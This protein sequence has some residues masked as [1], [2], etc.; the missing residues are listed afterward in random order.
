MKKTSAIRVVTVFL[1]VFLAGSAYALINPRFTPIHLVQQ[2]ETIALLKLAPPDEHG[3][4]A[5]EVRRGLKGKLAAAKFTIDLSTA[6]QQE[7]AKTAGDNMRR[8]G[9]GPALLFIGKDEDQES[10]A[11]LALAGQWLR[12]E[13]REGG[14]LAL[15]GHDT[16]MQGTWAGGTDMLLL[17]VEYI[18]ADDDADVP[19]AVGYGWGA[20]LTLGRIA[21][22]VHAMQAV[23]LAGKGEFALFI[24]AEG[25][26]RLYRW[27][28]KADGFRDIASAVKLGSKSRLA[29]WADLNGDGRRDL[30]DWDGRT[31]NMWTQ[32]ADG[33]FGAK[34]LDIGGQIKGGC[35]SLCAVDAG[36]EKRSGLLVGTPEGPLLLKPRADG[37]FQVAALSRGAAAAGLGAPIQCLA[38]DLDGD[39]LFD[40]LEL[41]SEGSLFYKGQGAGVFAEPVK[42]AIAAG[43]GRTVASVGDCDA[44]GR[45]DL[46]TCSEANCRLWHN[47]GDLKFEETFGLSGEIS[48]TAVPG[49]TAVTTCDINND[50]RQDL[51]LA[52]SDGPPMIFFNRGFRSFGKALEMTEKNVIPETEGGQ[53]SATVE[54]F[55]GDGA[56]DLAMTLNDGTVMVFLRKTFEDEKPLEARASLPP[57]GAFA[58]P[59]R[60][61]GWAGTRCLG[62][63]NVVAGSTEAFFGRTSAGELVVKWQLPGGKPQEKKVV[64]EGKCVRIGL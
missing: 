39:G 58:G 26:D 16:G 36:V 37:T 13:Q 53:Q 24:A 51:M 55:N 21:G 61:T 59:L 33:T 57:G 5:A 30:A 31:L 15:V 38:A 46:F 2:S 62:A 28:A 10:V 3:K 11:F 64:L 35:L 48:Y 19:A 4:V 14:S 42:C 40:I 22:K 56:Q 6:A 27:D 32:A 63:W 23:D 25:G 43:K 7:H 1:S 44:D 49:A 8:L 29:V 20:R 41:C 47:R 18:L 45:L 9:D 54:D 60:V 52:Y 17:A 50:G 12:L 34:G